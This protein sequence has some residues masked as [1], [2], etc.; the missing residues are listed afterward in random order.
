MNVCRVAP[1]GLVRPSCGAPV[2][3]MRGRATRW[4]RS[5]TRLR[6][7]HP[8]LSCAVAHVRPI[9]Q[10]SWHHPLNKC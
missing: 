2:P 5:S 8:G 7:G 4:S 10:M 1:H 9:K 6:D 3:G